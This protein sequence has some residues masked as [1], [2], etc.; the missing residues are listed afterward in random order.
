LLLL[1]ALI[2][3]YAFEPA[4]SGFYPFCIFHLATGLLCPG[5]GSLRAVHQL[6]HGNVAAAFR[7]NALLVSSLPL[8]GISLARFVFLKAG[9]RP[10]A[11][12][13]K[14]L[15]LWAGL[16]VLVC[17]GVLRNL[18]VPGLAWMRP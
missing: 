9:H 12:V 3:L 1:A 4:Q 13:L 15:W 8:V 18:H 14:P 16:V 10:S 17:F 11:F 2:V 7:F 5:C 6:L